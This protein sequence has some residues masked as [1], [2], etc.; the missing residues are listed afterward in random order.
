[1]GLKL[2]CFAPHPDDLETYLGGTLALFA[3]AGAELVF[4][5]ATD[6]EAGTLQPSAPRTRVDEQLASIA[7]FE[8]AIGRPCVEYRRMLLPDGDLRARPQVLSHAVEAELDAAGADLVFAPHVADGHLDHRSLAE[9]VLACWREHRP[10]RLFAWLPAEADA[11]THVLALSASDFAFKLDWIAQHASQIPGPGESRAHLPRGRD[12][13]QR[14][15]RREV[16]WGAA[17]G[18]AFGEPL[19]LVHP[20]GRPDRAR[21]RVPGLLRTH[22]DYY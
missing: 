19:V 11:A 16:R 17:V 14:I 18:T 13:V 3:R 22:L 10:E 9:A 20:D 8:G 7:Y 21:P 6:G 5:L 15:E 2:V 4:V 1:M 12:I